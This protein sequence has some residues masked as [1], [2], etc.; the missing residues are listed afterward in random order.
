MHKSS[1]IPSCIAMTGF[2]SSSGILEPRLCRNHARKL[3]TF[4]Y[5]VHSFISRL[6]FMHGEHGEVGSLQKMQEALENARTEQAE[7]GLCKKNSEFSVF[8]NTFKAILTET[9]I[10]LLVH[11]APIK[12][13]KDAVV[14][15]LCQ[16]KD[17]T[18]L[19]QPLDDENNKGEYFLWN[20]LFKTTKPQVQKLLNH[21]WF[22]VY[23]EYCKSL[24]SPNQ[25]SNSIKSKR[26]ISTSRR[27]THPVTSIRLS[28]LRVLTLLSVGV[29]FR[30]APLIGLNMIDL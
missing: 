17:I 26:R 27:E 20:Y 13:H 21:S 10:W 24:E 1:T 30:T 2:Q 5:Q 25:N 4:L 15:Y 23:P 22:Q 16:F 3:L 14:L 7:I 29:T 8:S 18:P 9:P 12:N 6:A 28:R 19:K 11:L